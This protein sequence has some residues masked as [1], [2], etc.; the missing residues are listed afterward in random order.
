MTQRKQP[1]E[2]GLGKVS[3]K[4][5]FKI[6]TFGIPQSQ[7]NPTTQQEAE[8]VSNHA[9]PVPLHSLFLCFSDQK[10]LGPAPSHPQTPA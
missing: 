10:Q 3:P 5:G 4:E 1:V 9:A 2:L 8:P 7:L 6:C